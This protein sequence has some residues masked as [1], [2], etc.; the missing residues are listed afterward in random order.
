MKIITTRE[1]VRKTKTYFDLAE[2]EKVAVKRGRKY[3]QLVVTDEPD[4]ILLSEDWI[5]EFMSIPSKYRVNPF[6][7]SP[8]GDLFF[9][10]TRNLEHLDKARQGQTLTLSKEEENALFSL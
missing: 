7:V 2:K 4:K 5:K 9:A 3:V 10:D 6:D 8:S 1:I